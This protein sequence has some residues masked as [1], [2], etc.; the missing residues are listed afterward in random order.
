MILMEINPIYN[1]DLDYTGI[2][3]EIISV[4][5]LLTI[6]NKKT[7]GRLMVQ[8]HQVPNELGVIKSL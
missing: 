3:L 8:F 7:D 4:I 2:L 5:K 1:T 6:S